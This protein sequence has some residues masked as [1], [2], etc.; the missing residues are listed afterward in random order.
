MIFHCT[1]CKEAFPEDGLPARCPNCSGV[2]TASLPP[3]QPRLIS[4]EA[5]GLW[6][7]REFLG[8]PAN[9]PEVYLGE[10]STPLVQF[11]FKGKQV[12]TKLESLNPTGSF[13]DRNAAVTTSLLLSRN[14]H[15]A[16]DDS[17]GNAGVAFA[18]YTASAGIQARVYVPASTSGPKLQQM[19]LSSADVRKVEG[20]RS[21]ASEAVQKAVEEE[22][23]PYASH[24]Y[25]P[26]C[27]T[28]Y[29]TMA[30]E[31]FE[32]LGQSP[33]TIIA[34]IGHGNLYLGIHH[35]LQALVDGGQIE[36]MPVLLGVQA[37]NCAP[38]RRITEGPDAVVEEG[39][40]L[41]EGIR[42]IQPLRLEELS[43]TI[44]ANQYPL[45][46]VTESAILTGL[47]EFNRRGIS[48]EKTSAIVWD[49]LENNIETL[50][51]PVVI[52]VTAHGL[53]NDAK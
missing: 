27:L 52:I 48:V 15:E 29:A 53:K 11:P 45:H 47:Q 46:F 20:P 50:P 49:A 43:A 9:A 13:K 25:L 30:Y 6:K 3:Y 31:I 32:Q 38:L 23:I 39:E 16:V 19:T 22:G 17:S 4:H 37:A 5:R 1:S 14:I 44:T 42:I 28:A 51:E 18:A 41:A 33:G 36:F 8:L 34:P 24:N 2:F 35:G 7:Y 12:F 10:G 21:A 26:L 40:T